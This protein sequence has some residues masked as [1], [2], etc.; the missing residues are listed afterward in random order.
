MKEWNWAEDYFMINGYPVIT[1]SPVPVATSRTLLSQM[2]LHLVL[3]VYQV[4]HYKE[5]HRH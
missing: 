1:L 2:V 5:M 4:C 3:P